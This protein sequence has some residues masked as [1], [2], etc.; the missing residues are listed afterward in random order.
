[1]IP[2]SFGILISGY[3]FFAYDFEKPA[4]WIG[5]YAAI[6]KSIWGVFGATFVTGVAL[7]TGCKLFSF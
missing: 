1:M 2:I 7:N 6:T 3:I 5:I 4:I